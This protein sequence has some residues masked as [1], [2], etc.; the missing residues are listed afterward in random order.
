MPS[1]LTEKRQQTSMHAKAS[2][3]RCNPS[4]ACYITQFAKLHRPQ[5]SGDPTA[6]QNG[7]QQLEYLSSKLA[8]EGM[9][10]SIRLASQNKASTG[11][12]WM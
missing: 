7:K 12:C 9:V 1:R 2:Q 4:Q 11:H 6:K 10:K 8:A 3:R 5:I